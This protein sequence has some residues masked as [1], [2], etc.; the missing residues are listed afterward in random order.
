VALATPEPPAAFECVVEVRL[1]VPAA[2]LQPAADTGLP[3]AHGG[4]QAELVGLRFSSA[5]ALPLPAGSVCVLTLPW[6]FSLPAS[7]APGASGEA[8]P[9]AV[10]GPLRAWLEPGTAVRPVQQ[11]R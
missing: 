5:R 1:E 7:A 10:L 4:Q 11:V 9:L 3:A 8:L 2:R 6:V